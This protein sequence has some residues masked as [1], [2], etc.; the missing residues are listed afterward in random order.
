MAS[1]SPTGAIRVNQ[2]GVSAYPQKLFQHNGKQVFAK[3]NTFSAPDKNPLFT[4]PQ[5]RAVMF[6]HAEQIGNRL[7]LSQS[8]Y[9]DAR[10]YMMKHPPVHVGKKGQSV[11]CYNTA[12]FD[13]L[14]SCGL[15]NR[16]GGLRSEF[17]DKFE[18]CAQ[19]KRCK[20]QVLSEPEMK[21]FLQ[22]L[23][24]NHKQSF[25]AEQLVKMEKIAGKPVD[26][27]WSSIGSGAGLII[28]LLK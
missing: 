26:I 15:I 21:T 27:P 16:D 5:L 6:E 10:D 20:K 1:V 19:L 23:M 18:L 9:E 4:K 24:V 22:D 2:Q 8:R 13:K 3:L 14:K 25:T 11:G 12:M 17:G 28:K 7:V